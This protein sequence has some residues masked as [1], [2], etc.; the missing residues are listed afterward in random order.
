MKIKRAWRT[1]FPGAW[2]LMTLSLK[3]TKKAG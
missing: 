1:P 2:W 3:T